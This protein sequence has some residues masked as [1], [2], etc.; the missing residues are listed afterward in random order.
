MP[1]IHD[2]NN[3]GNSPE[4][5]HRRDDGGR[6]LSRQDPRRLTA[7][8]VAESPK[9]RLVMPVTSTNFIMWDV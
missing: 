8:K 4:N 6:K 3:P 7:A 2:K 9:W 1:N 5:S